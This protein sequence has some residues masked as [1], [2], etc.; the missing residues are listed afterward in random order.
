MRHK[1]KAFERFEEFRNE[2]EMQTEKSLK[3]LWSDWGGEYL[4]EKFLKEDGIVS[5]WTPSEISQLNRVSKWRNWIL[6]DMVW[7]MMTFTDLPIFFWGYGVR[8]VS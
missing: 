7:S 8:C 2:V 3:I 6:L 1:S 5:Q 4:K